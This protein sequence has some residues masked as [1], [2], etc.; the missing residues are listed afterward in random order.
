MK[1]TRSLKQNSKRA[2]GLLLSLIFI[3]AFALPPRATVQAQEP[4]PTIEAFA[5]FDRYTLVNWP[6]GI[7]VEVTIVGPDYAAEPFTPDVSGGWY[8]FYPGI[9]L[10]PGTI[11]TA[12]N[13][14]ITK[15]LTIS[16]LSGTVDGETGSVTVVAGPNRGF[17]MRIEGDDFPSP[18]EGDYNADSSGDWSGTF[19]DYLPWK[20]FTRGEMWEGDAD[21]DVTYA[22]WHVHQPVIEVWLAENEIRAYDWPRDTELTFNANGNDLGTAS[23]VPQEWFEGTAA[24]FNAGD[25]NLEPGMEV[26]VSGAGISKDTLVQDVKI[27]YMN[28]DTDI[29]TGIGPVDADLDLISSA[30]Y[31]VFRFFNTGDSPEW[32][33]DFN[34]PNP[35]GNAAGLNPGDYLRLFMRDAE[36]DST[37]WDAWGPNPRLFAF[38]ENDAVEAV[39]WLVGANL[40]LEIDD[41]ANGSGVDYQADATMPSWAVNNFFRFEFG[42][43]YDLKVGDVVTLTGGS[44]TQTHTIRKLTVTSADTATNI[45]AGLAD[46]GASIQV[47]PN[48]HDQE[49]FI[50]ITAGEDNRWQADFSP[51]DLTVEMCGRSEI[52]DEYGNATVVDW[53]PP[54]PY[55]TVFPE[56]DAAEGWEWQQGSTVTM[57]IDNA[58][59]IERTGT[60]NVT[61]WGDPRTWVWFDVRSDYD[62]QIGDVVT[63]TDG[64]ITVAQTVQNLS[65]T[66]ANAETDTVSGLADPGAVVQVWPHE[67]GIPVDAP[68]AEDGTWQ[69][70]LSDQKDLVAGTCGRS[71]V[72]DENGFAT[73]VDWCAPKPWLIAFPEN[74]AV[75]GWEWP[76]GDNVT[77]TINNAP[78]LS[79]SG[80]ADV[81]AWGDPRTYVRFDFYDDYDLK[82][83]D[84]IQ[85]TD[86]TI[87]I[88]HTVQN[89][90]V[91]DA[92]QN[93]DF[94]AGLADN[95]AEIQVWPHG[96]DQ[97][98]TVPATAGEDNS[99]RADFTDLFD[100][101]VGTCGRSQ[102]TDENGNHTAVDWCAPKPWFAVFPEWGVYVQA[103]DYPLGAS[104]HLAID[105]PATEENP[106]FEADQETTVTDWNHN[107]AWAV[108][109][110]HP[111]YDVKPG[112]L[113]TV[114]SAGITPR[115]HTVQNLSVETVNVKTDTIAGTADSGAVVQ[116]WPW[117]LEQ[118]Y[119]VERTAVKGRWQVEYAAIGLDLAEG[120]SGRSQ[121]QIDGNYTAVDWDARQTYDIYAYN[122]LTGTTQRI[123]YLANT[124]EYNPSWSPN[125]KMVAHDVVTGDGVVGIYITD[126]KTGASAPLAGAENGGNDAVWSPNGKWIAFD[127]NGTDTPHLYIVPSGGGTPTLVRENAASADWAPNGKRLVFTD[128]TDG[129]IRTMAVDG[130]KGGETNVVPEGYDPVWSPDGNWIAFDLNGAVWKVRVSIQGVPQGDPIL[131]AIVGEGA[132]QPTWSPDSQT[133]AFHGGLFSNFDIW[134]VPAAGGEPAWLTGSPGFGDYDP[135]YAKNSPVVGYAGYAPR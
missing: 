55:F 118:D 70:D 58:P 125:G 72:L 28:I 10:Q 111:D 117:G 131:L 15:V 20:W 130:G 6:A 51:F 18:I 87:S 12:T 45:V 67:T 99:W 96:Y 104:V 135:A 23:T 80:I 1:K 98:A 50:E 126:V 61:P 33:V 14:D 41:P 3:L 60:A 83:G 90:S 21:G 29:V 36:N 93:E 74:D 77:L 75:E 81:T 43:S 84:V 94:V 9:D 64:V 25:F 44:A 129:S 17:H 68:V 78:G 31:P 121:I 5:W 53:C 66:E 102:T 69:V 54:K 62:I 120:M 106:D 52:P 47:W 110:F 46:P 24:V 4:A 100:L 85:L 108:F 73:A 115:E 57:T 133:I 32:T 88:E 86:G 35:A 59:G 89:L 8:A 92:N 116:V 27:T 97:V 7:P 11:I 101:G 103:F 34:Q 38:P 91:L 49:A 19:S 63:L 127:R 79:W 113:V 56:I 16:P 123:T 42:G 105:D 37:V 124:D 26:T 128:L 22:I 109:E 48:G 39:E 40:H 76:Q 134:T 95:G 112:D 107:G 71:Q 132:G 30:E 122:P 65:V 114:T 82:I 2:A 13:G 119:T